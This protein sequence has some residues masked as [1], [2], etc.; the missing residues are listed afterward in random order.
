MSQPDIEIPGY[1]IESRLGKG[2]MA[3]VYK[4]RQHSFDRYVAIKILKPDYCEDEDFCQRFLMESMIVAK[5]SHSNVVQVYDVGEYKNSYYLSMELLSGGDLS[6]KLRK[7]LTVSEAIKITKQTASALDAAHRKGIIHRDV[8][9][10]NILFREDG[11]AVLTD[12]GIAK[13]TASDINLTQTGFMVGTPKYMSPEQVRGSQVG[14]PADIYSLGI[15]FFQLLTNRVPFDGNT[16]VAVAMKQVNDPVPLLPEPLQKLQPIV[17]KLLAKNVDERYQNAA[18]VIRDL[19]TIDAG[20]EYFASSSDPTMPYIPLGQRPELA[21]ASRSSGSADQTLLIAPD[22]KSKRTIWAASIAISI[23]AAGTI[24]WSFVNNSTPKIS[25]STS[26]NPSSTLSEEVVTKGTSLTLIDQAEKDF[27]EDR[28]TSPTGNNAYEK[29]QNYLAT[30][31]NDIQ[32]I[33]LLEKMT[34]KYLALSKS[35]T[36]REEFNIA[37]QMLTN[38]VKIIP[39]NVDF[40]SNAYLKIEAQ[41]KLI[42]TA[43]QKEISQRNSLSFMKEELQ[44]EGLIES[45][46]I[47]E[48][49]GRIFSPRNNNAVEKYLKVLKIQPDN[50]AAK[51]RL[52]KLGVK[53]PE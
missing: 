18:E 4:A 46:S 22:P 9:P 21:T 26:P 39:D 30:H 8:K 19:E 11:A 29:I 45:A 52:R 51:I 37:R 23:I 38:A 48:E 33:R 41:K 43:S 17:D 35:A 3:T 32:A 50:Q 27:D 14:P 40:A 7:G 10:D 42:D 49:Q 34:D 13:E 6:H 47:D 16:A 20:T 1:D 12:F 36:S 25:D 28:L 53:H 31:P 24:G 2:G 5:V 15:L 44:I